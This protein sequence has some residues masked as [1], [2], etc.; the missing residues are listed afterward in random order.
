M[1][2]DYTLGIV[3]SFTATSH[4]SLSDNDWRNLL[5]DR[6]DIDQYAIHFED[7]IVKGELKK[8]VFEENI[9]DFYMKLVAITG[10]DHI[11]NWFNDGKAD[12]EQYDC[13]PTEM[14]M[15]QED[16]HITLAAK[17]AILFVEGKVLVEEFETEPKLI[18]WLF[19]HVDL[20][21][22]LA[23]CVMSDIIG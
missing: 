9:E 18:N 8:E 12:M 3:K 13:W 1:G 21:N 2:T 20:S 4:Q 5:N 22:K 19:R 16:V 17:L 23:G 15:K 11:L 7:K 10:N 6:I 14:R